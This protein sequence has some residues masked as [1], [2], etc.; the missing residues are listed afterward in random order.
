MSNGTFQK[1]NEFFIYK[2]SK[3][4]VHINLHVF[5]HRMKKMK[6]FFLIPMIIIF[7]KDFFAFTILCHAHTRNQ[8]C[9]CHSLLL[10]NAVHIQ[11]VKKCAFCSRTSRRTE[12]I[13]SPELYV[14]TK[15]IIS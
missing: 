13:F 4:S 15:E 7:L 12:E 11:S 9:L 3:N 8:F 6:N 14:E 5:K 1:L 2:Q 10:R